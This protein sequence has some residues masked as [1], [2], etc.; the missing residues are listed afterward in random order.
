MK[1]EERI[2]LFENWTE[3]KTSTLKRT[4]SFW[5]KTMPWYYYSSRFC[6]VSKW[7]EEQISSNGSF[8]SG[9]PYLVCKTVDDLLKGNKEIPKAL[10]CCHLEVIKIFT[11][12]ICS[13]GPTFCYSNICNQVIP[14]SNSKRC[15]SPF[16]VEASHSTVSASPPCIW[17]D[18]TK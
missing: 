11:T 4:I 10:F 18:Y 9:L 17:K 3:I 8:A 12:H 1:K 15:D 2:I 16:T 5:V 13:S 7:D 14:Q 6:K